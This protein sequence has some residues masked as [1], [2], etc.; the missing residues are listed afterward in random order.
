MKQDTIV[1]LDFGSQYTQLITRIVRELSVYSLQLPWTTSEKTIK[2]IQPAGLVLSGG[3]ASIY[4]TNAPKL[5]SFLLTLNIPLLGI[6]YGMQAMAD[7]LDG[8]ISASVPENTAIRSLLSGK[9]I[10]FS[11]WVFIKPGC[12]MEIK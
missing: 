3:P 7:A 9:I 11:P 10:P 2:E 8:E 5:P 4:S 12:P 1:I 6:C